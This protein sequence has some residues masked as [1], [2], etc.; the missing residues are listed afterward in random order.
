[1]FNTFEWIFVFSVLE[2]IEQIYTKVT[3]NETQRDLVLHT[4]QCSDCTPL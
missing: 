3:K 4:V 2:N 1:M